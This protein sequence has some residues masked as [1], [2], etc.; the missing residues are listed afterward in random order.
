MLHRRGSGHVGGAVGPMRTGGSTYLATSQGTRKAPDRKAMPNEH[1]RRTKRPHTKI[2]GMFSSAVKL[3]FSFLLDFLF[4]FFLLFF[5][6]SL[7]SNVSLI[8]Y[9]W[10]GCGALFH[11]PRLKSASSLRLILCTDRSA[12]SWWTSHRGTFVLFEV[13]VGSFDG[14]FMRSS[15]RDKKFTEVPR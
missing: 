10:V 3:G 9:C 2:Y 7:R 12:G 1:K 13:R 8:R 4:N 15:H 6:L 5:F 14:K 11:G